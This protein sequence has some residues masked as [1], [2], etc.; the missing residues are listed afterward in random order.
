MQGILFCVCVCV[1]VS[2]YLYAL[3]SV[4]IREYVGLM[5][6]YALLTFLSLDNVLPN[7]TAV[8]CQEDVRVVCKI[9][10]CFLMRHSSDAHKNCSVGTPHCV[11]I[12]ATFMQI[13]EGW[14][15]ADYNLQ[16]RIALMGGGLPF[17][18]LCGVTSG[19][20]SFQISD[21]SDCGSNAYWEYSMP[22][23]VF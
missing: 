20:R 2:A 8:G 22:D 17:A 4:I 11:G 15:I 1:C 12:V 13:P 23:E 5:S 6:L 21:G 10:P 9:R 16:M 7:S 18:T 19:G 3:E 14:R